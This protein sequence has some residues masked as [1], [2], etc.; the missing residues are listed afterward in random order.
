MRT[1]NST[2]SETKPPHMNPTREHMKYDSLSHPLRKL[3]HVED[4][5]RETAE[6]GDLK[7]NEE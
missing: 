7:A 6:R 3:E 2:S 4:T 5:M 1:P